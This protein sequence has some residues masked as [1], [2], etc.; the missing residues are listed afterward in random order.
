VLVGTPLLFLLTRMP[1]LNP[2]KITQQTPPQTNP[3]NN[4]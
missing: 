1:F 4:K 3:K 2:R